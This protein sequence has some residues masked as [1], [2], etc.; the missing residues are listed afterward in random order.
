MGPHL[1]ENGWKFKRSVMI[2]A[3]LPSFTAGT[4][5]CRKL[6]N[7]IFVLLLTYST[8]V[9]AQR[10]QDLKIHIIIDNGLSLNNSNVSIDY[11]NNKTIGK[12]NEDGIFI[13]QI[14]PIPCFNTCKVSILAFM[15]K[16]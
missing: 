11:A 8:F 4:S 2:I 3:S 12:T 5:A 10:P 7:S 16:S 15:Y 9:H 14:V 1:L 13:A 6:L